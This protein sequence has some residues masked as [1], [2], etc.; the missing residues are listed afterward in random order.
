MAFG[1]RLA[2]LRCD[3]TRM[4]AWIVFISSFLAI[5]MWSLRC[6]LV[7]AS[8]DMASSF[9]ISSMARALPAAN[10]IESLARSRRFAFTG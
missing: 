4:N 1:A 10:E 2:M 9:F 3:T 5:A 6:C 7:M 8:L